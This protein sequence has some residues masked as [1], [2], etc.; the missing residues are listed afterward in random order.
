MLRNDSS[1][2][3][4]ELQHKLMEAQCGEDYGKKIKSYTASSR[5]QKDIESL[6]RIGL[7]TEEISRSIDL[8]ISFV[9]RQ[10]V[11]IER[12]NE[13]RNRFLST[14]ILPGPDLCR[15]PSLFTIFQR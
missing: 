12:H 9:K 14:G 1:N 10:I 8:P 13:A 11:R 7:N 2:S 4:I 15:R 3:I 6:S 5:C